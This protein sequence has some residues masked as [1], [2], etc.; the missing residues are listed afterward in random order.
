MPSNGTKAAVVLAVASSVA[1]SVRCAR[2]PATHPSETITISVPYEIETLDP[3][4]SGSAGGTAI[5]SNFYEPLVGTDATLRPRPAL[6]TAWENPDPLT[7]TFHLRRDV[8]FHSG[9]PLRARDVAY[10]IA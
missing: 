10:S 8:R 7:W 4:A 2:R 9:R 3:H 1:S 5:A 6:A